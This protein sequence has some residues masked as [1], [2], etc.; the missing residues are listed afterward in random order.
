VT[1]WFDDPEDR[2]PSWAA[3][4]TWMRL[5]IVVGLIGIGALG[6]IGGMLHVLPA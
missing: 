1:D 2:Q 4:E 5:Y 6:V 3:D